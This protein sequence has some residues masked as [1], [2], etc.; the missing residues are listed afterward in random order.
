MNKRALTL[1]LLAATLLAQT[2]PATPP[3]TNPS[4]P[5]VIATTEPAPRATR[6]QISRAKA[7]IAIFITC[8][9]PFQVDTG[10]YPT[11]AE[12]L[13]ALLHGPA[14]LP[15]KTWKGP[16]IQKIPNDPWGHP[17]LYTSPGTHNPTSYD[18]SSNGPDNLPN[19]PDDLTNFPPTTAPTK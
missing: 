9:D 6:A 1:P 14:T 15:G 13:D 10:R 7:D 18:L 17:Y 4:A 8:L 5:M 19:T 11:T 2:R 12:G 3:A 16:Y